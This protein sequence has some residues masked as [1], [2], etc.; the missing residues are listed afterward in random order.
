MFNLLVYISCL[1]T[2]T[3]EPELWELNRYVV[4][5]HAIKWKEIGGELGLKQEFINNT[6]SDFQSFDRQKHEKCLQEVFQKWL[7]VDTSASWNKLQ[8][9]LTNV[10]RAQQNLLPVFDIYGEF[11][12]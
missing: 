6:A 12:F 8:L 5:K 2:E 3:K 10:A 11:V 1:L 7:N 9:V 4:V